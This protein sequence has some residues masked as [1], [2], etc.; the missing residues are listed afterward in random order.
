MIFFSRNGSRVFSPFRRA[1]ER[2]FEARERTVAFGLFLTEFV[3]VSMRIHGQS[4]FFVPS[5][6]GYRRSWRSDFSWMAQKKLPRRYLGVLN[7]KSC[8]IKKRHLNDAVT[9]KSFVIVLKSERIAELV[10][11]PLLFGQPPNF[12]VCLSYFSCL[13]LSFRS[14]PAARLQDK[15]AARQAGR[16]AG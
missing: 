10:R 8:R 1:R 16:Q 4:T 3:R 15:E 7:T 9:P 2:A 5:F 12:L 13:E 14:M 11:G 6:H